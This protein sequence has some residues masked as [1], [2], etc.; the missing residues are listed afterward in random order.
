MTDELLESC[1]RKMHALATTQDEL[2][3]A[4]GRYLDRRWGR[5]HEEW[6]VFAGNPTILDVQFLLLR[7]C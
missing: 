1:Q 4:H 3:L 6:A 5:T 7:T 2:W